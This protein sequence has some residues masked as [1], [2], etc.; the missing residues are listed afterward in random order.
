MSDLLIQMIEAATGMYGDIQYQGDVANP[1]SVSQAKEQMKKLSLTEREV[2]VL[3]ARSV[4]N[5]LAVVVEPN[6][7]ALVNALLAA[8]LELHGV[9]VFEGDDFEF[10]GSSQPFTHTPKKQS[11]ILAGVVIHAKDLRQSTDLYR[12]ISAEH[13]QAANDYFIHHALGGVIPSIGMQRALMFSVAIRNTIKWLMPQYFD[14]DFTC[15]QAITDFHM[16]NMKSE[17]NSGVESP[18]SF[19]RV[20]QNAVSLT[21]QLLGNA[22]REPLT[23]FEKTAPVALSD[24]DDDFLNY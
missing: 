20:Q 11:Q 1:S 6:P 10:F 24:D 17:E 2:L 23:V 19:R 22:A 15:Y 3:L 4:K 18:R 21:E 9:M 14:R 8:K 7:I 13:L 5:E 12:F 16:E